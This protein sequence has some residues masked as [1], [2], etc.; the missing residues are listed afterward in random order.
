[1]A[2]FEKANSIGEWFDQRLNV[3]AFTKVMMTEYWIPKE[4]NFL[5]AMGALLVMLFKLLI[6]TGIFL[7]MYYKPD[8]NMA[9]DSVN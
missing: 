3:K 6:I 2:E 9:F 5:W 7:L 1:M 8:V 4:I